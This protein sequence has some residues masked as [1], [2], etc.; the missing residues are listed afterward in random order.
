MGGGEREMANLNLDTK[1][2]ESWRYGNLNIAFKQADA[3]FAGLLP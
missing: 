1:T 2:E 3:E